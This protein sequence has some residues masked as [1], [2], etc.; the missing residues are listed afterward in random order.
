M[1]FCMLFAADFC[2]SA[3]FLAMT[4]AAIWILCDVVFVLLFVV[5]IT[6]RAA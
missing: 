5:G 4:R 6:E 1:I 3:L 2:E